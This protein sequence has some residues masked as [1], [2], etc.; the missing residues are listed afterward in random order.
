MPFCINY[1]ILVLTFY[2]WL[3]KVAT[4]SMFVITKSCQ[5]VLLSVQVLPGTGYFPFSSY[6]SEHTDTIRLEFPSHLPFP[7]LKAADAVPEI[8]GVIVFGEGRGKGSRPG[9]PLANPWAGRA[10]SILKA[11]FLIRNKRIGR[12]QG[13]FCVRKETL[14]SYPPNRQRYLRK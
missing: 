4:F 5:N 9:F 3:D 7:P 8:G 11:F 10:F 14:P 2:F 6:V 1:S 13:Y 12:D